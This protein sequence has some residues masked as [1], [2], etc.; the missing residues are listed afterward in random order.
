MNKVI[1]RKGIVRWY[2]NIVS[3][4]GNILSTSQ[5]YFSKSNARRAA[6]KA[7]KRYDLEYRE[8]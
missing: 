6:K 7:T 1:L 4:N 2:Y 3:H 5:K 8:S